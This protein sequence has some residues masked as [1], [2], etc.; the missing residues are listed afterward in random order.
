MTKN[1]TQWTA[2]VRGGEK[3]YDCTRCEVKGVVLADRLYPYFDG[4]QTVTEEHSFTAG[5]VIW[6]PDEY[7]YAVGMDTPVRFLAEGGDYYRSHS[8]EGIHCDLSEREVEALARAATEPP[9][10]EEEEDTTTT[11]RSGHE[12]DDESLHFDGRPWLLA[13]IYDMGYDVPR[14]L[15]TDPENEFARIEGDDLRRLA[16]RYP[17]V[18]DVLEWEDEDCQVGYGYLA[19]TTCL[20]PGDPQRREIES[21][22]EAIGADEDE[23]DE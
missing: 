12:L 22:L 4:D 6:V 16:E 3:T 14:R 20:V 21:A 18:L 19:L 23:Q 17:H 2:P 10:E 11:D 9:E 5:D 1:Y 13:T 7:L 8:G 15:A